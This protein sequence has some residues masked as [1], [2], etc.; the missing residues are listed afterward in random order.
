MKVVYLAFNRRRMERKYRITLVYIGVILLPIGLLAQNNPGLLKQTTNYRQT[1]PGDTSSWEYTSREAYSYNSRNQEVYENYQV[2]DVENKTW[3]LTYENKNSYDLLGNRTYFWS[4]NYDIKGNPTREWESFRKY[5]GDLRVES[6]I[7]HTDH[8]KG[9]VEEMLI[10]Y[11]FDEQGRQYRT[12]TEFWD[13]QNEHWKRIST[14]Y[15]DAKGCVI[16]ETEKKTTFFIDRS[17][18]IIDSTRT[19]YINNCL[20]KQKDYYNYIEDLGTYFRYGQYRI[21]YQFDSRNFIIQETHYEKDYD[22][23]DWVPS[24]QYAYTKNDDG[25]PLTYHFMNFKTAFQNLDE[26]RYDS[27]GNVIFHLNQEWDANTGGWLNNYQYTAEYSSDS[28]R[29]GYL[30]QH[31]WDKQTGDYL[32]YVQSDAVFNESNLLTRET[33]TRMDINR[34]NQENYH[35]VRAWDYDNRCDGPLLSVK[36]TEIESSN[37]PETYYPEKTEHEYFDNAYCDPVDDAQNQLVIYPNPSTGELNIYSMNTFGDSEIALI[38]VMGQQVYIENTFL[39]NYF[40][41]NMFGLP[42]GLYTL[43][44]NNGEYQYSEKILLTN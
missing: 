15:F 22:D 44:I 9:H 39:N 28:L 43:K 16:A 35:F 30:F 17:Y 40:S 6:H 3:N 42:S 14:S 13:N 11:E 25:Q 32:Y 23:P 36:S 31:G 20:I 33:V 27:D 1:I 7:F 19:E 8:E 29:D 34:N 41:L 10:H 4:L 24:V 12:T 5:S 21:D 26:Y 37:L 38:N 18:D 2:W